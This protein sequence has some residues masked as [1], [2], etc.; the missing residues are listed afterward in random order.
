VS[1]LRRA[2]GASVIVAVGEWLLR[3]LGVQ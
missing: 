1:L 2:G 3:L